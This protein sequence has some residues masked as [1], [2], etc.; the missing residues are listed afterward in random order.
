[1]TESP[2]R[3][4]D[5][6]G[7]KYTRHYYFDI[8][9]TVGP[10]SVTDDNDRIVFSVPEDR[11]ERSSQGRVT[12]DLSNAEQEYEACL[13]PADQ[14]LKSGKWRTGY[15]K[16]WVK[17]DPDKLELVNEF[18][19]KVIKQFEQY[20]LPVI[21]LGRDTSKEAIC[22]VFEKVNTGGV[23][24]NVFE[25]MTASFAAEG[26]N[27]R[28]DWKQREDRLKTSHSV[29]G[30]VKNDQ[31]L[32]VVT[33]LAT[34]KRYREDKR[35][36]QSNLPRV[37]CRRSDILNLTKDEYTEWA[38]RVEDGF[39]EVARFLRSQK[40]FHSQDVPYQA[41]LVPL[42]AILVELGRDAEPSTARD[43]IARWFWNG[44]MGELYGGSIETQV[45][46][47][48][49]EVVDFV[50]DEK[51]A[52]RTI[53]EASFQA[54]RLKTLRS[55]NSA[56]YKGI[57]ALL[58]R[59][60]AS[61]FRTGE[62]LDEKTFY[63]DNIDIHHIF[64]KGWCQKQ[65]PKIEKE[66]YDS[67]INKTA[68]SA[69]TN[70]IIGARAPSDYL[71]RLVEKDGLPESGITEVLASHCI[72]AEA[73]RK[74]DFKMFCKERANL[75]VDLV[76]KVMGKEATRDFDFDAPLEDYDDGSSDLEE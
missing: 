54:S 74:D 38:Q 22:L 11:I 8:E 35:R 10:S 25:L 44:V 39:E 33:M 68:I 46:R 31:F 71:K 53:S 60:G 73:L 58:M 45:A 17:Q 1:M 50:R 72:P 29:L 9:K 20:H 49:S 12:R 14:I 51:G 75:L 2:V 18:E 63:N 76:E 61:D 52:P 36:G 27:L 65:D 55:R 30:N 70:R 41:Q 47:D 32:Q 62:R 6:K 19:E 40:I 21:T 57:Y 7:K 66:V 67:I 42:A 16:Y 48:M 15:F 3:T 23:N 59:E 43:V 64:P 37:G 4:R 28:D 34:Q 5:T 26:F 56:A 69:Q 13:F 24:L